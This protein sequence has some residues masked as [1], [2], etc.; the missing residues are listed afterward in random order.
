VTGLAILGLIDAARP[1]S[2]QGSIKLEG[3]EL[4][5]LLQS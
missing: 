3:E 1:Q 2:R 4:I 5:G